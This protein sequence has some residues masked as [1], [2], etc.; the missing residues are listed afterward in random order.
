MADN[1]DPKAYA[2]SQQPSQLDVPVDERQLLNFNPKI[3]ASEAEQQNYDALQEKY[4]GALGATKGLALGAAKAIPGVIPGLVKSG[5]VSPE[6]VEGY[7]EANPIS[8]VVGNI[9]GTAGLIGATGGVGGLL[10]EGAGL[11]ARLGASALEGAA[12]GANNVVNDATLGDPNLNAQKIISEVGFGALLGLGGH[13][14]TEGIVGTAKAIP[15]VF[16]K[17]TSS[18]E[19]AAPKIEEVAEGNVS[20]SFM[21][22]VKLGMEHP[23]VDKEIISRNL[24][25]NLQDVHDNMFE[26][27]NH[28]YDVAKGRIS[29]D[30]KGMPLDTA[31]STMSSHL[32]DIISNTF[33]SGKLGK[34]EMTALANIGEDAN[35][36]IKAADSAS[37]VFNIGTETATK[38]DK[39]LKKLYKFNALRD[40]IEFENARNAA[41]SLRDDLRG[42]LRNRDIWGEAGIHYG[43][44]TDAYKEAM[45]ASD[46]FRSYFMKENPVRPGDYT[47]HLPK[48]AKVLKNFS[49]ELPAGYE[50]LP[51][52]P[53]S[54][55]NNFVEKASNMAK[56]GENQADYINASKMMQSHLLKTIKE[57]GSL[58]EMAKVLKSQSETGSSNFLPFM[59]VIDKLPLPTGA[60]T[61]LMSLYKGMGAA[62]NPYKVGQNL[63][64]MVGA[65]KTV[66]DMS[67]NVTSNI[68]RAAAA[69][70]KGNTARNVSKGLIAAKIGSFDQNYKKINE[71]SS[72]PQI[73]MNHVQETMGSMNEHLPNTFTGI[74]QTLNTG[75]AFLNSKLP[76]PATELP[77]DAKWEATPS[78]KAKFNK[79]YMA[80]NNPLDALKQIR[81]GT[82]SSETMEAL[83]AVHPHL[84]QEMQ[85]QVMQQMNPAK[86]SKLNYA[87]KINLSTFLGQP[88]SKSLT[89]QSIMSNQNTFQMSTQNQ[90]DAKMSGNTRTSK[91]GMEHM[92]TDSRYMTN[93]TSRLKGW[94]K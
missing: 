41:Y 22:K 75:L 1:F 24:A 10:P 61:T 13:A 73:L 49:E 93:T 29:H 17:L 81:N 62:Q 25:K 56:M 58:A 53:I 66:G 18:I 38:L 31:A 68:D 63:S 32:D 14:L 88:L 92:N 76:R 4:G 47:V 28:M 8:S 26:A 54:V 50:R 37:E 52:E 42:M 77:L 89:P 39:T 2:A 9:A 65:F 87:T 64:K 5:M 16:R 43:E 90:Q 85:M 19:K 86:A 72:D 20:K 51:S 12:F 83:K 45:K 78:Q 80:V 21:D 71:L 27:A 15:P 67:T 69:I 33:L 91:S 7:T 79:Y 94:S 40:P 60:K 82:L 57:N 74:S 55:I 30:L 35:N 6:S 23:N 34:G 11:A 59:W 44:A 36:A 3:Y 48:M 70:F 46:P 84:L